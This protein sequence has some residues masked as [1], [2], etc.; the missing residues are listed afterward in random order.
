MEDVIAVF[1]NLLGLLSVPLLVL[2]NAFFVAAEFSLVAVRKTKVEE[3]VK[4]KKVGALAV[5][6]AVSHLDDAIAATQLGITLASLGLGWVGEPA[7][8]QV[9]QPLLNLLPLGW[10][11]AT[12]HGV[13]VTVAF[14]FITFL[15]VVVGELAPKAMA[16]QRPD[17]LSL[18]I[19]T[20]LLFFERIARPAIMV[21]NGAGN[22]VVRRLG[23]KPPHGHHLVHSVEE[24]NL[25]VQETRRAGMIAQDQA[26][27]LTNV[28]RLSQKTVGDIMVPRAK[29]ASLDIHDDEEKILDVIREG[30]H[31]RVPI[32]NSTIDNIVGV[33]NTKDLFYIFS[34]RG[35]IMLVDAIRP[36]MFFP[37][38]KPVFEALREFRKTRQH[39][40]VVREASGTV[41]GIVTLEDVLEEIVG[42]IEDEHDAP[43]AKPAPQ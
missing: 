25:L 7:I 5:K 15:H 28:F 14:L 17:E 18:F 26:E 16:L 13:S 38:Q 24:L 41:L 32:Y 33:L 8:T 6:Q 35:V 11:E 31:T 19:A 12:V 36:P 34:L 21:M 30:A 2:L 4:A 20:P 29:M 37:P 10:Q 9:L 23:M 42:E 3:M 39:L 43:L 22:W 27:Y 40:A 1:K